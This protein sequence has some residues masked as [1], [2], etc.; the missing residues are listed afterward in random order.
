MK[1]NKYIIFTSMYMYKNDFF[2]KPYTKEQYEN[3]FLTN[4]IPFKYFKFA[5]KRIRKKTLNEYYGVFDKESFYET[6]EYFGI[7]RTRTR[8]PF[9]YLL[10]Y[11]YKHYGRLSLEEI[12][13]LENIND[14]IKLVSEKFYL[15]DE[16]FNTF[17]NFLEE[18]VYDE[19]PDS[20]YSFFEEYKDWIPLTNGY[21]FIGFDYSRL[22]CVIEESYNLG[23]IPEEEL[24]LISKTGNEIMYFFEDWP[25][26][27]CSCLL[28]KFWMMKHRL[29]EHRLTPTDQYITNIYGM[30]TQ[31]SNPLAQSGIWP[32]DDY[33]P[34]KVLI[35]KLI[36]II[37][38]PWLNHY[39]SE[40]LSSLLVK[41]PQI[42]SII[43]IINKYSSVKYYLTQKETKD[44]LTFPG[45]DKYKNEEYYSSIHKLSAP[46]EIFFMYCWYPCPLW[47][48][49]KAIYYKDG[50]IYGKY[51]RIPWDRY[52]EE[53]TFQTSVNYS[54]EVLIYTSVCNIIE[55]PFGKIKDDDDK[56]FYIYLGKKIQKEWEL[57]FEDLCNL[58]SRLN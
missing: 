13:S 28:G 45:E 41:N 34:L 14:I 30:I 1:K 19:N 52:K 11:V 55:I 17:C 25:S 18:E 5:V 2:K 16:L 24:E 43:E 40:R 23:Y 15:N 21:M 6:Y 29:K 44:Y 53:I 51:Y 31:Q 27:L 38:T 26:F 42:L 12:F 37:D 50:F 57:F 9:S 3:L 32:T 35:E 22:I 33:S 20:Y 48:S 49:N 4:Y 56:L 47:F 58:Y 54:A 10:Y 39:K 8:G 46:G 7:Y 36:P